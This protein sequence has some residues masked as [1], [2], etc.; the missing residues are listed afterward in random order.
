M[1]IGGWDI[2]AALAKAVVYAA[3]L[4][5]AGAVFFTIHCGDLLLENQRVIVRRLIGVL[6][7]AGAALSGLR[8]LLLGA[9]MGGE[10]SGMVDR[11]FVSMILSGGEGRGTGVRIAGLL[12][13]S[14][15]TSKNPAFRAPA[16]VGAIIAAT[17]FAWVGHAHGSAVHSA[18]PSLLLGGFLHLAVRRL[19]AGGLAAALDHRGGRRNEAQIAA[20]AARFGKLALA[21]VGLLLAA[22]AS[23]LWMFI[24]AA[25][26][27]W[28]SAYGGIMAIKLLAVAGIF[29]TRRVEQAQAD[30]SKANTPA[31][32]RGGIVSALSTGRNIRRRADPVHHRCA[33][34][35]ERSALRWQGVVHVDIA[36]RA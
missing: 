32:G 1:E 35:V 29:G 21:V 14:F 12:L 30:A 25:D 18:L 27:F 19:L 9:S 33:H 36:R 26:K 28:S 20:A 15:A 31:S 23:L 13:A 10:V 6:A 5:A 11:A 17:S 7:T 16:A 8:I 3:T 2:A 22:G 34:H 24:A 4:G